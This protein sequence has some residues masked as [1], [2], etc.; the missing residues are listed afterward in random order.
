MSN[1]RKTS[2]VGLI[3]E[4]TG[5]GV[6]VLSMEQMTRT[7][8]FAVNFTALPIRFIKTIKVGEFLAPGRERKK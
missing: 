7:D 3:L 6:E 2:P 8:P 5:D 1:L 4:E